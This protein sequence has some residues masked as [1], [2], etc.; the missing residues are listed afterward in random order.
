VRVFDSWLD[1]SSHGKVPMETKRSDEARLPK[2]PDP[3]AQ[4]AGMIQG[5]VASKHNGA[6]VF[7]VKK[8]SKVWRTNRAENAEALVGKKVLVTGRS[9]DGHPVETV[10]R[11]IAGLQ[12]GETVE[13]DVAHRDGEALT[14]LELTEDQ[15]ER[16]KQ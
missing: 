6:I 10:A 2:L 15:R 8:V 12:V 7:A 1:V 14:I 3:A 16:V 4:F 9:V 5:E 13:I 11:F